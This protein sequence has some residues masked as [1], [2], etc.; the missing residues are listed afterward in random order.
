MNMSDT[1]ITVSELQQQFTK[2]P[3]MGLD[4]VIVIDKTGNVI[5][6]K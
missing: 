2:W 1:K 6:V 5:R 4:K 3:I